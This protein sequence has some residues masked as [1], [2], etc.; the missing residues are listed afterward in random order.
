[1]LQSEADDNR[2]YTK[3][4]NSILCE[5]REGKYHDLMDISEEKKT[6]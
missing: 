1:M 4:V 5:F 3:G 6:G 2:Y